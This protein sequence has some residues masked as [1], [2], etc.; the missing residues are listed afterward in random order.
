M[1]SEHFGSFQ[2]L[3]R[4][5]IE[6][7]V[8]AGPHA[9]APS[10]VRADFADCGSRLLVLKA[11]AITLE[12]LNAY[13]RGEA[14]LT[15]NELAV[16]WMTLIGRAQGRLRYQSFDRLACVCSDKADEFRQ[17]FRTSAGAL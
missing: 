4:R 11:D 2:D 15:S 7:A 17:A 6:E 13:A 3:L 14:T 16:L 8:L 9:S 10:Q 1:A 12:K 5:R